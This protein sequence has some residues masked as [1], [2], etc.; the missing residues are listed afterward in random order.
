[1]ENSKALVENTIR[2]TFTDNHIIEEAIQQYRN[3]RLAF[4]GNK[5]VAFMLID[6]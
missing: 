6:P 1:M 5:V 3:K 4:L 2:Y